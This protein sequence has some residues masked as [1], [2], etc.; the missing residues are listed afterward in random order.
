[1]NALID[2]VA[3]CSIISSGLM[4]HAFDNK[5]LTLPVCGQIRVMDST[6]VRAQRLVIINME[7]EFNNYPIKCVVLEDDT[8]DPFII[9]TDFLAHPEINAMLNFKDEI[10]EIENK[11]LPL[12]ITKNASPPN[13]KQLLQLQKTTPLQKH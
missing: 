12:R 13:A 10:I 7:S 8:Q 1:M 11:C 9:S 2:T 3:Q 4:K 5:M 6:I